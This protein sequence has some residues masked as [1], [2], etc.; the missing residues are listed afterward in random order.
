MNIRYF[1]YSNAIESVFNWKGTGISWPEISLY[2]VERTSIVLPN[3]DGTP[4]LNLLSGLIGEPES[5]ELP[6]TPKTNLHF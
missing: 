5:S 3:S 1:L 6:I 4:I 2:I